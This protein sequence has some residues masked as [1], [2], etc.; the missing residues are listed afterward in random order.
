MSDMVLAANKLLAKIIVGVLVGF[1][2]INQILNRHDV[3]IVGVVVVVVIAHKSVKVFLV[4]Q[5]IKIE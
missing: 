3:T 5:H 4:L 1:F 2:L